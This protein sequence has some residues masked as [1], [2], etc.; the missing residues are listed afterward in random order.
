MAFKTAHQ[1]SPTYHEL[2]HVLD[3]LEA[4]FKVGQ[5][6]PRVFECAVMMTPMILFRGSY[7]NAIEADVHY[8]PLEKDFS[9]A[10]SILARLDDLEYLQGFADRAYQRLVGSGRY[11][12]RS[13]ARLLEA[14]IEQQYPLRID[15]DWVAYRA[16][17]ARL[18]T[19]PSQPLMRSARQ[20]LLAER[21]SN[22]PFGHEE[23][24]GRQAL[25]ARLS[26]ST[27]LYRVARPVWLL[28][29][30]PIRSTIRRALGYP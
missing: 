26:G 22:F 25:I 9:N 27:V 29:P 8:I 12:Y 13:L 10:D 19:S 6:S 1:R 17:T 30:M 21:P 3:P 5:I 16:Q 7:S 28:L 15:P 24:K 23:F 4:P 14:T 11:G 2:K 18:R 20:M